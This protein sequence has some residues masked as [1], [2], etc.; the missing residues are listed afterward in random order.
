M[1]KDA[2]SSL[3]MPIPFI[4]SVGV[5][6]Y[7]AGHTFLNNLVVVVVAEKQVFESAL[8]CHLIQEICQ[9]ICLIKS[10][11][12]FILHRGRA[13]VGI[14]RVQDGDLLNCHAYLFVIILLVV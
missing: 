2:E 14:I 13:A 6:A 7:T 10:T 11:A 9:C 12:Q 4:H 3:L 8:L 1:R 5:S